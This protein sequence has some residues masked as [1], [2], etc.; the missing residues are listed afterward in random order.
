MH[1]SKKSLGKTRKILLDITP[2]ITGIMDELAKLSKT[3]VNPGEISE[4]EAAI[5]GIEMAKDVLDMLVVRQYDGI[6]KILCALYETKRTDLESK[7]LGEIVEMIEETL[8]D[9][10]LMRFF[11]RLRLLKQKTQSAT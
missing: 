4:E 9:Q 11:P 2:E 6:V 7:E 8:Q 5:K 1:L 10:M 3:R